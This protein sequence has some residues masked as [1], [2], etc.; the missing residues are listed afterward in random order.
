MSGGAVQL[1][2]VVFLQNDVCSAIDQ[3]TTPRPIQQDHTER[4]FVENVE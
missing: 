4:Q 3:A 2:T 1:Q